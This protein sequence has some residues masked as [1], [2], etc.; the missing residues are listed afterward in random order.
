MKSRIIFDCERMK[1]THTGLFSYCFQLGMQLQDL[2]DPDLQ[3]LSFFVPPGLQGIFG[4]ESG[5]IL[6]NSL[7][8]FW[9]PTLNS[10]D[11]WHSTYQNSQYLPARNKKVKVVLTIHDLN[12]LYEDKPWYKKRK[13]LKH[14]QHN[15]DRSSAVVCISEF[16]KADVLNYCN[17]TGKSVY[18]IHNG[19]NLL[20]PPVLPGNSYKPRRKFLFSIGVISRKKNF[21]TLLPLIQKNHDLELLIAGRPDDQDYIHF[22]KNQV[23]N[24]GLQDKVRL[25]GPI[26]E[27]EKSWYYKNCYAFALP[28]LAEGFGLPVTEAMSIGK[29]VFLSAKT[30]LP[31]IAKDAAFY[32][33]DFNAD[34]MQDVFEN[35]MQ[36]YNKNGMKDAIRKRSEDFCWKKA[37]MQYLDVYR[38]VLG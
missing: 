34:H 32:F 29:P 38:C 30:A 13:Y 17:V 12:F 14:L 19:T 1:Y 33:G 7:Q 27:G 15:I 35:G 21:H 18:V 16:S 24:L 23:N 5:Y 3:E 31:E 28:S 10:Y 8:K 22:I 25:L 4:K 20:E 26:T 6:Q 37:A 36:E 11:I 9:L 2:A